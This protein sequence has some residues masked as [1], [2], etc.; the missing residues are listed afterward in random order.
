[1]HGAWDLRTR[2]ICA[3]LCA[4]GDSVV[5]RVGALVE[6]GEAEKLGERHFMTVLTLESGMRYGLVEDGRWAVVEEGALTVFEPGKE[7]LFV[8][9][10]EVPRL[11]FDERLERRGKE[12]EF[13]ADDLLYSFPVIELVGAMLGSASPHFR[14]MALMWLLPTELRA[15]RDRIS[16]VA[17]D[18]SMPAALRELAQRMVVPAD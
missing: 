9:V 12:L 17:A 1:M 5:Q 4:M 14:R 2:A 6:A 18:R 8:E 11:E 3:M 7:V 13:G 16:S 10:F 15:L